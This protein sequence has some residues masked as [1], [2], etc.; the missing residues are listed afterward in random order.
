MLD[1]ILVELR[2]IRATLDAQ[3]ARTETGSKSPTTSSIGSATADRRAGGTD[4]A[5]NEAESSDQETTNPT[6]D[7]ESADDR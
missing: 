3:Q 5:R 4:A 2:E 1:D 7:D 6:P